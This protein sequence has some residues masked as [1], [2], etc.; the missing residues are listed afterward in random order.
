[1]YRPLIQEECSALS[2]EKMIGEGDHSPLCTTETENFMPP[3]FCK[4]SWHG[5]YLN[6]GTFKR[7]KLRG[8]SSLHLIMNQNM[9]LYRGVEV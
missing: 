3:H 2:R 8:K 7:Y 6:T 9:K 1:M 4:L 5:A